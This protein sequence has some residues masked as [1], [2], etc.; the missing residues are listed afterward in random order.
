MAAYVDVDAKQSDSDLT[1][2]V[3]V[4]VRV[5]ALDIAKRTV[6]YIGDQANPLFPS[7]A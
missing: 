4:A 7:T 3:R 2:K 1:S 5:A 6:Q